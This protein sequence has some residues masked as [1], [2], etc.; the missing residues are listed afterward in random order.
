MV[1][2]P[3]IRP[4]IYWGGT[5]DSHDNLS[6]SLKA[7]DGLAA[8]PRVFFLKRGFTKLRTSLRD[9]YSYKVG[10]D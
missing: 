7:S 9:T 2:S 4:A 3:L 1:N 8:S 10:P 6:I 5:L